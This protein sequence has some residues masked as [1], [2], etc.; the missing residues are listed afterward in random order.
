MS[1]SKSNGG[2]NH[3]FIYAM[4]FLEEPSQFLMPTAANALFTSFSKAGSR[5]FSSPV[6]G[7][8]GVTS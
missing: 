8:I 5:Q 7:G 1:D 4:T 6:E 2:W 3:A